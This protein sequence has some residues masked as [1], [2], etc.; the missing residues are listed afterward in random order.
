VHLQE[1]VLQWPELAVGN[2]RK[3]KLMLPPLRVGTGR[4]KSKP[5]G[6]RWSAFTRLHVGQVLTISSTA[7]GRPGLYMI[8]S[9][10]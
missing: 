1:V 5:V 4:G 2:S 7:V 8:L 6:G 3:S 10:T 9:N